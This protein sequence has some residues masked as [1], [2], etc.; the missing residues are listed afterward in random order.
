[1]DRAKPPA[2]DWLTDEHM[3]QAGQ[4]DLSDEGWRGMGEG[5]GEVVRS[6]SCGVEKQ[7][8]KGNGGLF[9]PDSESQRGR[10]RTPPWQELA[11]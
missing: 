6:G 3:T 8:G 11:T 2:I 9:L 10:V 7:R 5:R 1:M 4:S